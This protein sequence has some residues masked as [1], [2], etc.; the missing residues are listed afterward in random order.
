VIDDDGGDVG[1]GGLRD[2]VDG[3][4][5]SDWSMRFRSPAKRFFSCKP[6]LFS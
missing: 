4:E 5:A 6:S 3:L 1:V 2:D